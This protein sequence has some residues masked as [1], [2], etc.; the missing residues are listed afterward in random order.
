MSLKRQTE[1]KVSEGGGF[2]LHT[3]GPEDRDSRGRWRVVS[4]EKETRRPRK[5]QRRE[6]GDRPGRVKTGRVLR[7]RRAGQAACGE[8]CARG[9]WL[10]AVLLERRGRA[11][12]QRL[13]NKHLLQDKGTH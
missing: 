11:I 4:R 3:L 9:A 10:V 7:R 12:V 1:A 5:E 6:P 2:L 13:I 8:Q